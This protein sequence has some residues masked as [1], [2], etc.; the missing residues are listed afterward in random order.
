MRRVLRIFSTL[1]AVPFMLLIVVSWRWRSNAYRSWSLDWTNWSDS[2]R[3]VL[4]QIFR[5]SV[6]FERPAWDF[7]G[8]S[9]GGWRFFVGPPTWAASPEAEPWW[10]LGAGYSNDHDAGYVTLSLWPVVL[11]LALPPL[12]ALRQRRLAAR[13]A[14]G[15][16]RHCGYDLRA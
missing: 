1:L 13:A 11:L 14:T 4:V 12:L 15:H 10:H 6:T 16:C 8:S 5:G 2:Q 9:D 7:G 3:A